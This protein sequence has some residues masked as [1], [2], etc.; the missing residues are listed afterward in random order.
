MDVPDQKTT[1]E[2][3]G[4]PPAAT[5]RDVNGLP[6]AT[7]IF[8]LA[9][10]MIAAANL[11]APALWFSDNDDL[12]EATFCY[13]VMTSVNSLLHWNTYRLSTAYMHLASCYSRLG[14]LTEAAHSSLQARNVM[15][16]LPGDRTAALSVLDAQ[17]ADYL[18]KG[19][20]YAG[21]EALLKK[22]VEQLAKATINNP[23]AK[24]Y[25]LSILLDT[26]MSQHKYADAEQI[27]QELVPV[28]DQLELELNMP[29]YG[30]RER[31]VELYCKTD[32]RQKAEEAAKEGVNMGVLSHNALAEAEAH[33]SLGRAYLSSGGVASAATE[34]DLAVKNLGRKYGQND[35]K[36]A[37]WRARY[38]QMLLDKNPFPE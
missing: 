16:S 18:R 14:R 31:L 28:D 19:K 13:Q 3:S 32:R 15:A 36:V 30:G 12:L 17:R 26:Y 21:A 29:A 27:A 1:P 11:D 4:L 5:R 34:F 2:K 38:D 20:D 24:A 22:A 10:C 7:V 35:R 6:V 25:T 9:V 8:V 33:D 37:T 23:S